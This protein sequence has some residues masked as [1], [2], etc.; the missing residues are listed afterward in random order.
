MTGSAALAPL[1]LTHLRRTAIFGSIC[2][3]SDRDDVNPIRMLIPLFVLFAAFALPSPVRAS[4]ALQ[5]KDAPAAELAPESWKRLLDRD[6]RVSYTARTAGA[7]IAL[8]A[9]PDLLA[10]ERSSALFAI[11]A[12]GAQT[13]RSRLE[14]WAVE[15]SLAD[16]QAA[17]LG[18]G[19]LGGRDTTL[20]ERIAHSPQTELAESAMLALLRNGSADARAAVEKI[21][22]DAGSPQAKAA[23]LLIAFVDHAADSRPQRVA[24]RWLELRW[25]AARRFGLIDGGTW[26][27]KVMDGLV[28]DQHFLDRVIYLA[29]AKL[30]DPATRDHYLE[31]VLQPGPVERVRGAVNVMTVD[32]NRMVAN[33]LWAPA[34]AVEW[35]ELITEIDNQHLESLCA[36]ILRQA[37]VVA[38]L[39]TYASILL[40]R[41]GNKEGLPL[42]ELEINSADPLARSR[43]A[44][45][46]GGTALKEYVPRLLAMASDKDAR[47]RNSA[48]VAELSLGYAPAR[49][50]IRQRLD[51]K[52][53]A[54]HQLLLAALCRNARAGEV[55]ALLVDVFPNMPKNDQ[56]ITATALALTGRPTERGIVRETLTDVPPSGDLG[57]RMVHAISISPTPEDVAV[58]RNVFP[59]EGEFDVNVELALGLI[60]AHDPTCV[61]ILRAALWQ[62]PWN[63]SL[64]AAALWCSMGGPDVLEAELQTP[65]LDAT[66]RD[67]R[68]VGFAIGER[69]GLERVEAMA[70]RTNASDPAVQGAMLGALAGRT[71]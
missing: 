6:P 22:A 27:A 18:L 12:A 34:D 41:G 33:S 26:A 62:E 65:P 5:E 50:K 68:R 56:V 1:A 16:R 24:Q 66:A 11:G 67:L 32:L 17:L 64:L 21:A 2:R 39:R 9:R 10:I 51:D 23:S 58:M 47:V 30:R 20:L 59:R 71:R 49:E 53:D 38:E 40:V 44:E 15:G 7:A 29:A 45:V 69:G 60:A 8:L 25:E 61:P 70:R 57:A 19:E 35:N 36:D 52:K 63:R 46:L 42:L 55:K 43:I 54:E 13:E 37:R 48:L 28:H 14:S 4:T 3:A 31:L